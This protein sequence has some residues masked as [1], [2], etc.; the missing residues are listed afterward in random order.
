VPSGLILLS[1]R[2]ASARRIMDTFIKW[3]NGTQNG[4]TVSNGAMSGQ[5]ESKGETGRRKKLF[6]L[7]CADDDVFA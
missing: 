2:S 6:P 7:R 4:T 1:D 5:Q 3:Q